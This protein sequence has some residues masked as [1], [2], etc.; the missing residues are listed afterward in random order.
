M[1]GKNKIINI[2][3]VLSTAAGLLATT[4]CRRAGP[5]HYGQPLSDQKPT[6]LGAIL[7]TPDQFSGKTVAVEG[8]IIRECPTGCWFYMQQNGGELYIDLNP[9]A[10]AIPQ[11]VGKPVT[12]EGVVELRNNQPMLVGRGVDIR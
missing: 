11:R 5:E 9:S 2:V 3:I 12:V 8:K 6:P 10:F 4:G 7:K 1:T